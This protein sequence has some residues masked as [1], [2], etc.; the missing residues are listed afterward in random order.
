MTRTSVSPDPLSGGATG[1]IA[2]GQTKPKQ[3]L[4]RGSRTLYYR[5]NMEADIVKG[6]Q[7]ILCGLE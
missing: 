4:E 5:Y 3:L 2:P 1:I 6:F 7:K